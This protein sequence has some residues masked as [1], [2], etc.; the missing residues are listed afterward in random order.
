L[1][2]VIAQALNQRI[3]GV[4]NYAGADFINRLEFALQSAAIFGLDP[5]LSGCFD[6]FTRPESGASFSGRSDLR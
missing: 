1:A 2:E 6:Q 5:T 4:F 3:M